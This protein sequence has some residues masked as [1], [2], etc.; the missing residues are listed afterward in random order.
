V[1]LD[2]PTT[3]GLIDRFKNERLKNERSLRR[4]CGFPGCKQLP[5]KATFSRVFSEF[6]EGKLAERV[7]EGLIKDNLGDQFVSI[8]AY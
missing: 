3:I 2:L 6:A 1:V 5:S 4:I 8:N 7:H